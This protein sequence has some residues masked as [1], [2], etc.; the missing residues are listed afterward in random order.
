MPRTIVVAAVQMDVK[1]APIAERLARAGQL[2]AD[3]SSVGS[4][5]VVLPELFNTGYAYE[6][7]NFARAEPADGET[8]RWMKYK[9]SH[10]QVHL[11]GSLLLRDDGKIYNAMFI[12]APDGQAWRYDK[13]YPWG[14]ERAYF[15][16]AQRGP[17]QITVA[18]TR[19][20]NLGM[21]ICWDAAH[22]NLWRK[23]AGRVDMIVICSSPPQIGNPTFWLPD[24]TRLSSGQLGLLWRQV[25]GQAN[26]IFHTMIAEQAAWLGVPVANSASCG[27]FESQVPNG[28][29][30]L[31]SVAPGQPR[32]LR[33]LSRA[34]RMRVT[35]GMVN[36]CRIVSREGE[37]LAYRSQAGGEG[38]IIAEIELP[39]Q[40][41]QPRKR[42]PTT[43]ASH[44]SYILSDLLLPILMLRI[45]RNGVTKSRL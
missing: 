15:C 16:P 2:I 39:S 10:F 38:F 14:W 24:G 17:G 6:K 19:L 44:L 26:Q 45:Y 36:A 27:K 31:L 41:P 34:G 43:R 37:T 40:L 7:E 42:Q 28:I 33:Y 22:L 20:G 11:A 3:A 21:L 1:P 23:Y 29:A 13:N 12:I 8:L 4:N 5:L 35:T 25:K 32:L 9:A 18:H 30:S